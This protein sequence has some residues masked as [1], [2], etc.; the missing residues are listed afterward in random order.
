MLGANITTAGWLVCGEIDIMETSGQPSVNHGTAHGPATGR[1]RDQRDAAWRR[2]IHRRLPY[3]CH[4]LD[5]GQT[6]WWTAPRITP[7][8]ARGSPRAR[9]GSDAPALPV[10]NVAVGG[11]SGPPDATTRFPQEMIVDYVRYVPGQ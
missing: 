3:V 6:P 5:A 2:A 11:R 7:W 9:S 8:I 4:R 1:E 10:V